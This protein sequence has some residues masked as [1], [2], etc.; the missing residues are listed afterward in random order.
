MRFEIPAD[1]VGELVAIVVVVAHVCCLASRV[2]FAAKGVPG[3]KTTQ[4]PDLP[5]PGFPAWG[6]DDPGSLECGSLG[7][8]FSGASPSGVAVD[9]VASRATQVR[10]FEYC[11]RI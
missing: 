2:R 1:L 7:W 5:A 3:A 9:P 8:L 11:G 4:V 6:I 10:A